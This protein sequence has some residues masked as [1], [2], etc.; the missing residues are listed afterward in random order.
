MWDKNIEEGFR[1][2][3]TESNCDTEVDEIY[4]SS[5]NDVR[6]LQGM[7]IRLKARECARN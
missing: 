7:L 2:R 5:M 6:I 1:L 3:V 4:R